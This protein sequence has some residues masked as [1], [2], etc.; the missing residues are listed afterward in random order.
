MG[1][2]REVEGGAEAGDLGVEERRRGGGPIQGYGQG[3]P[4]GGGGVEA[5]SL[6]IKDGGR[7]PGFSGSACYECEQMGHWVKQWPRSTCFSCRGRGHLA[8]DCGKKEG[9]EERCFR[10]RGRGHVARE[11]HKRQDPVKVLLRP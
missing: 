4:G 2:V 1:D 5:G 10:C 8:C 9:L 3:H 6:K 7:Q 11:C